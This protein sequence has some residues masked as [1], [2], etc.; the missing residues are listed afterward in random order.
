MAAVPIAIDSADDPRLAEFR[1]IRERDLTGRENRFIAEGTVVLRMLAEAHAGDR[2]FFAEKI[3]LL[4]NRV[5]GVLPI[6]ERFPPE[7]IGRASCRERV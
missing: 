1:D 5:E 4:R 6:L 7:E 2:G 3:L